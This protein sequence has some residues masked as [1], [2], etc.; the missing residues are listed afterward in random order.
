EAALQDPVMRARLTTPAQ[1]TQPDLQAPSRDEAKHNG[2][3]DLWFLRYRNREGRVCKGRLTTQEILRRLEK[4]RLPAT[5]EAAHEAEGGYQPLS[6]YPEFRDLLSAVARIRKRKGLPARR[7]RRHR[8][9]LAAQRKK[10][11]LANGWL[12][13][14][15]LAGLGVAAVVIWRL[16]FAP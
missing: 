15:L 6:A 9:A 16:V 1:P 14:G 2:N 11:F 8:A 13:L 4:G 7:G 10:S 3:P 5:A 12:W